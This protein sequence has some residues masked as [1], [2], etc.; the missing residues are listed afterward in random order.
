MSP[1]LPLPLQL[2]ATAVLLVLLAWVVHLIRT[3]RLNLRDSLA[4]L[5]STIVALL[6]TVFPSLLRSLASTLSVAVPANAVF[7][8]GFLYVLANLLACTIAISSNATRVRRLSQECSLLRGELEDLR[9][10]IDGEGRDGAAA[11]PREQP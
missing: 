6:M 8:L 10:R 4:W 2:F 3:Q 11:H 5:L 1:M 9:K 7:A